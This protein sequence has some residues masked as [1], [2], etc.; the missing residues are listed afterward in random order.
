MTD[1]ATPATEERVIKRRRKRRAPVSTA[2]RFLIISDEGCFVAEEDMLVKSLEGKTA[3][4]V[5]LLEKKLASISSIPGKK[6]LL[7]G[8]SEP[9]TIKIE[10]AKE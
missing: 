9:D 6:D 8:T 3:S 5:Y 10:F 2:R 7:N 4:E 1:T